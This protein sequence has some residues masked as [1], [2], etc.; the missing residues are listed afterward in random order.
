M[1]EFVFEYSYV[2][3]I[4]FTRPILAPHFGLIPSTSSQIFMKV[5]RSTFDG[6]TAS[7]A[8]VKWNSE[9]A[10]VLSA[11]KMLGFITVCSYLRGINLC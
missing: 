10:S 7:W 4:S 6:I 9:L 1:N 5:K 11:E 8:F 2:S 3:F